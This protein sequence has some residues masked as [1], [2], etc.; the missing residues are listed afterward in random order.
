MPFLRPDEASED[1]TSQ[2]YCDDVIATDSDLSREARADDD[3]DD[4]DDD[5]NDD[6]KGKEWQEK[7]SAQPSSSLTVR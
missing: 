7:P 2:S 4:D 6:D 3:D 1:D 5:D